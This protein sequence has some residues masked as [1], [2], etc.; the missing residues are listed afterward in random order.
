MRCLPVT[1][2]ALAPPP[3]LLSSS[4]PVGSGAVFAFIV[5]APG[6]A[7]VIV[8]VATRVCPPTVAVSVTA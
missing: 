2:A 8:P 4:R 5:P 1:D 3:E 6:T 7:T